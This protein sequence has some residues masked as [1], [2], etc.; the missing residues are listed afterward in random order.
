MEQIIYV[1]LLDEGTIVYRPVKALRLDNDLFKILDSP[2]ADEI[3]EFQFNDI[4][5]CT[6]TRISDGFEL[7]ATRKF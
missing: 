4:V 1:K 3:W 5:H 2:L 7:V 6:G